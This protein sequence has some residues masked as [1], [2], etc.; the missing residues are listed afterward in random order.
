[1][2]QCERYLAFRELIGTEED[3]TEVQLVGSAGTV[4]V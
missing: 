2:E 1:M 4:D 3:Y